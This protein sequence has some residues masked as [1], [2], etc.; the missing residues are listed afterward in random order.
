MLVHVSL[1]DQRIRLI[2]LTATK[3]YESITAWIPNVHLDNL[4]IDA[5]FEVHSI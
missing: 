5:G 2:C 1:E 4:D 3:A